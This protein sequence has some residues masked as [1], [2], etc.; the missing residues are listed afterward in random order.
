MGIFAHYVAIW[1]DVSYISG[2]SKMNL[3]MGEYGMAVILRGL[4]A[5]GGSFRSIL[6]PWGS[7][8][9]ISAVELFL[10][11]VRSEVRVVF[12]AFSSALCAP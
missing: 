7:Y 6:A 5:W 8:G 11:C 10:V 1:L 2:F 4:F 9:R 3:P 12:Y